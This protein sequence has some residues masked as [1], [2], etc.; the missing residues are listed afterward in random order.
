MSFVLFATAALTA[1]APVNVAP[2]LFT[3][4]NS[5]LARAGTLTGQ[6]SNLPVAVPGSTI[7]SA[8]DFNRLIRGMPYGETI[9]IDGGDFSGWKF[10]SKW[11]LGGRYMNNIC[12]SGTKMVQTDWSN[13]KTSGLGFINVD[14][15]GSNM[16]EAEMPFVLFRNTTLKDVQASQADWSRG[17]LDGGWNNSMANLKIE[18]ADLSGFRFVCGAS[19]SN[20]C[21][22]DRQGIK[23][24]KAN[25]TNASIYGFSVLDAD[26][27]QARIE[28]IELGINQLDQLKGAVALGSVRLRG[29]PF[30]QTA[31]AA[32]FNA[33]RTTRN[34]A[35]PAN[36]RCSAPTDPLDIALCSDTS[37]LLIQLE[38]DITLLSLNVTLDKKQA[39]K[40]DKLQTKCLKQKE[41]KKL[42]CF[43]KAYSERR[44]ELVA[45]APAPQWMQQGG[46]L[47]FARSELA[48]NK[49]PVAAALWSRFGAVIAGSAEAYMAVRVSGP[50]QISVRGK[51]TGE[52]KE[53]CHFNVAQLEYSA[54]V[55]GINAPVIPQNNSNNKK[56]KEK[57]RKKGQAAP[58]TPF[59]FFMGETAKLTPNQN[60]Q[61]VFVEGA[62][63]PNQLV[64]CSGPIS[65]GKMQQLQVDRVAFDTIWADSENASR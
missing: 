41:P 20:G 61:S 49:D 3:P 12:F 42:A 8:Q 29:G 36:T 58:L 37:K 27:T 33:L 57:K 32:E 6:N 54:G 15:T 23:A 2:T 51:A 4:V 50:N 7:K 9:L 18:D 45:L 30:T 34:I 63:D 55:F 14:F 1:A 35:S 26:F 52:D 28:G 21:P 31:T 59:V 48:S 38:E 13:A 11:R 47:I 22:F 62:R 19:E 64:Q 44:A 25:L 65:F 53:N 17:Q 39:K 46:N 10:G 60:N 56:Q 40:F 5:C 24:R 16:R 43:T